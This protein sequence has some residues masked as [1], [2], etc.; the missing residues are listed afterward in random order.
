MTAFGYECSYTV[1]GDSNLRGSNGDNGAITIE[2]KLSEGIYKDSLGNLNKGMS[3][4]ISP[5][6]NSVNSSA[7]IGKQTGLTADT[8]HPYITRMEIV[9]REVASTIDNVDQYYYGK[10]IPLL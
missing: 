8:I 9:D 10:A 4:T 7:P 5:T 1:K 3:E 6:I 2:Y